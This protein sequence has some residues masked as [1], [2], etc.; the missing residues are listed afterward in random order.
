M[1]ICI[2]AKWYLL[3]YYHFYKISF[4]LFKVSLIQ[5]FVISVDQ[6]Y[7]GDGCTSS[8]TSVPGLFQS[9]YFTAN[10]RCCSEDGSTCD[11]KGGHTCPND[12]VPFD[13]AV[14]ECED[15]GMRLCTKDELLSD[16]CCGS[17]GSCDSYAI[18]TST[19]LMGMKML[20]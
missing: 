14:S 6:Y 3:E 1:Q 17:G 11:T 9:K 4:E 10:V 19:T 5:R 2:L 7:V 12:A 16:V 13:D 20:I 8:G 18:W 15:H